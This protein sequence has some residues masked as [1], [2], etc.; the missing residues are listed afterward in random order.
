MSDPRGDAVELAWI[1]ALDRSPADVAEAL[2][3]VEPRMVSSAQAL[4]TVGAAGHT[5]V[6]SPLSGTGG[7]W[8]LASGVGLARTS[9][10]RVR[11]LSAL[12]GT[13]VEFF[14]S[15][16][17]GAVERLGLDADALAGEGTHPALLFVDVDAGPPPPPPLPRPSRRWPWS[18]SWRR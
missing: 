6:L 12:L 5:A 17:E 1:A 13:Q 14:V 3:L 9:A 18:P 7:R 11:A 4:E 8:T 2:G 16:L 10:R 15:D